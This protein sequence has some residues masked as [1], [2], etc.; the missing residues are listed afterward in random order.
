MTTGDST[1]ALWKPFPLAVHVF[2]LVRYYCGETRDTGKLSIVRCDVF[3]GLVHLSVSI[4]VLSALYPLLV[5]PT[6]LSCQSADFS[7]VQCR[8]DLN[9]HA[10]YFYSVAAWFT[11]LRS[12]ESDDIRMAVFSRWAMAILFMI[13]TEGVDCHQLKMN[14]NAHAPERTNRAGGPI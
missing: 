14:P 11:C 7:G 5:S 4:C 8:F 9:M 1:H 12:G 3:G 2:E 6:R 10:A 13:R